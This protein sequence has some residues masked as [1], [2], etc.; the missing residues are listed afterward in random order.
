MHLG[1]E[2]FR[3]N[4]WN[5]GERVRSQNSEVRIQNTESRIELLG[6]GEAL[7]SLGQGYEIAI[8]RDSQSRR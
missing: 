7:K 6:G 2:S 3:E 8:L 4:R 1:R 5:I